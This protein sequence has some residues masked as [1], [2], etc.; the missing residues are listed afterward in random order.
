[1][2]KNLKR[3]RISSVPVLALE[4]LFSAIRAPRKHRPST[5]NMNAGYGIWEVPALSAWAAMR[6]T[7]D[8]IIQAKSVLTATVRN[9]IIRLSAFAALITTMGLNRI[10]WMYMAG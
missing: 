9:G 2:L 5:C 6:A 1:M 4:A 10:T 7:K 3:E 8:I